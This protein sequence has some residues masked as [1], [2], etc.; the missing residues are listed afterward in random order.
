M[1][2]FG[3]L[4]ERII[5]G[6]WSSSSV[7]ETKLRVAN[8]KSALWRI[9]FRRWNCISWLCIACFSMT[10]WLKST[11]IMQELINS[12][13]IDI[14]KNSTR[15]FMKTIVHPVD[16]HA[17]ISNASKVWRTYTGQPVVYNCN[18]CRINK[19]RTWIKLEL[20][21]MLWWM[22]D[23]IIRMQLWIARMLTQTRITRIQTRFRVEGLLI[24]LQ[25]ILFK[26]DF[27][28]NSFTLLYLLHSIN[29]NS[30]IYSF[31]YFT[32]FSYIFNILL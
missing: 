8:A 4:D 3:W 24:H 9:L 7:V 30:S 17:L 13:S 31:P 18:K 20:N 27:K 22:Q 2:I 16:P 15:W 6:W 26:F 32:F 19:S 21:M 12:G 29:R 14:S 5:L 28:N 1:V 23:W 25:F 10:I 11:L